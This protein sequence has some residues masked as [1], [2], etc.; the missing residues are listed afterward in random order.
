MDAYN[1]GIEDFL[2]GYSRYENP[3]AI[4]TKSYYEWDRGWLEA[5]E[6][7]NYEN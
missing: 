1:D 4:E 6:E 2:K 5:Y 3:Y 7:Y